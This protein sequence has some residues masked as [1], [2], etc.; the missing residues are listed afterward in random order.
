MSLIGKK[1]F[2]FGVAAAFAVSYAL[3]YMQA[4]KARG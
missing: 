4:R 3:N 1:E 2:W